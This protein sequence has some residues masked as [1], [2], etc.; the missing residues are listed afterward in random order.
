M[1]DE[2]EAAKNKEDGHGEA[3]EDLGALEAKWVADGG[4]A[5]YFKVSEDFDGNADGG[6]PHVKE[7]EVGEGCHGKRAL[8]AEEDVE[9]HGGVAAAPPQPGA[10]V[11][12]HAAPGFAEGRD[13]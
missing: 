11:A 9:G 7:D 1:R 3:G 6:G 2:I 13:R 5:P 12:L 8:G 10:L 4:A